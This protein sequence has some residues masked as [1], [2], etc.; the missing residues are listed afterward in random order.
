MQWWRRTCMLACHRELLPS[1]SLIKCT[2]YSVVRQSCS[3]RFTLHSFLSLVFHLSQT[4]HVKRNNRENAKWLLSF[5][6]DRVETTIKL[7]MFPKW[8]RNYSRKERK[9][10]HLPTKTTATTIRFREVLPFFIPVL[11]IALCSVVWTNIL[12]V[13]AS[14]LIVR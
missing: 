11:I 10:R 14:K 5:Q 2:R 12:N 13:Y 9:Q 7:G 4:S 6:C 8:Q 1:K 3:F